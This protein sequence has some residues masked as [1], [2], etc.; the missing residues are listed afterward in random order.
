MITAAT[1]RLARNFNVRVA[2]ADGH[3]PTKLDLDMYESGDDAP[4][5]SWV[6]LQKAVATED[7]E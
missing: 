7:Q 6:F 5:N 3:G 1:P 4:P 2:W